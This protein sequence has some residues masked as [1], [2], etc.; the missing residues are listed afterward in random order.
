M[1]EKKPEP[2][3]EGEAPPAPPA[4]SKKLL[5]LIIIAVLVLGI[6]AAAVLF[7]LKSKPGEEGED[8]DEEAAAE[9]AHAK[10]K[11]NA[12]PPVFSALEPFTV[13]LIAE[14]GEQYLRLAIALEIE[15]VKSDALIKST[16]PRIRNTIT[17]LLSSKKPSELATR[18]GKEKLA[19]ELKDAINLVLDPPPPAR[20]PKPGEKPRPVVI[21]GPVLGVLFTEFI[22]Q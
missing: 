4:R 16:M 19:L 6:A 11:A 8:Y 17:L 9:I 22:I 10:E 3:T 21:D 15:D 13:N 5:I 20:A 1:A 14:T 12:P 2:A 18:E 7:L